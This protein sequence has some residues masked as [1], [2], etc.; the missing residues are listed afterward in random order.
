MEIPIFV[1]FFWPLSVA[2]ILRLAMEEPYD[3]NFS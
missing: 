3:P 2:N 1:G